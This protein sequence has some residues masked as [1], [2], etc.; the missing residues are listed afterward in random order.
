VEIETTTSPQ[1]ESGEMV[2]LVDEH[3]REIGI[4][5]KLDAH[6]DPPRLHRAF[7]VFVFDD[8][9]RMLLQKRARSK[10]HFGGL[11]TNACCSHPRP[12]ETT[13]D[14]ARRRMREELGVDILLAEKFT[15]VYRAGD[16]ASGLV[17]WEFDHVFTGVLEVD[18]VPNPAEVEDW[19]WIGE[20]ELTDEIARHSERFTP[21]FLIARAELLAR[22]IDG[23]RDR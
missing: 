11:W 20:T 13:A 15:F 9:C 12:G 10:Y 6:V 16:M 17:E 23:S 7:S 3:D 21:W 22:S 19:R 2:I 8:A 1:A 4:A 14:A 5:P 18:P